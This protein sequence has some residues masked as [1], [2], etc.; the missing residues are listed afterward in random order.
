MITAPKNASKLIVHEEP[1]RD[2][3]WTVLSLFVAYFVCY[4]HADIGI[5]SWHIVYGVVSQSCSKLN[6]PICYSTLMKNGYNNTHAPK[7]RLEKEKNAWGGGLGGWACMMTIFTQCPVQNLTH[8]K[9]TKNS[10]LPTHLK[11]A[12]PWL[13]CLVLCI[14]LIDSIRNSCIHYWE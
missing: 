3:Q 5:Y 8:S 11:S 7:R 2:C 14:E 10:P 9:S 13:L 12:C 1:F 4:S 6:H